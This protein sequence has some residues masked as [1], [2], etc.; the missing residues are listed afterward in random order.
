MKIFERFKYYFA[1]LCLA[2]LLIASCS[3]ENISPDLK[4]VNIVSTLGEIKPTKIRNGR[5][6]FDSPEAF[7]KSL[8]EVTSKTDL[9]LDTWEKQI[10]FSSMRHEFNQ[11]LNEFD[12]IQNEQQM[13]NFRRKYEDKL[14]IADGSIEMLFNYKAVSS[15]LDDDGIVYVGQQVYKFF[16]NT[17]IIIEDFNNE[18]FLQSKKPLQSDF[19]KGIHVISILPEVM[20][21]TCNVSS[22]SR[23]DKDSDGNKRLRTTVRVYSISTFLY[24]TSDNLY[25]YDVDFFLNNTVESRKKSGSTWIRTWIN[26]SRY[27]NATSYSSNCYDALI[28][29]VGINDVLNDIADWNQTIS[30]GST[31]YYRSL[32]QTPTTCYILFNDIDA[33]I[34]RIESP[35]TNDLQCLISC[36]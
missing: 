16:D 31:L 1:I 32:V 12:L 30:I 6:V 11:A 20:N 5:L 15:L 9:D 27:I 7:R 22:I 24:I 17:E 34:D 23:E 33:T 8:K 25:V 2:G 14:K 4:E 28:D 36:F 19:K 26:V 29:G 21:R 10:G 3:K 13:S 18:K 35:D